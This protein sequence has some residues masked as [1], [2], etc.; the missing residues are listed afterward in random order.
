MGWGDDDPDESEGL[1]N[2]WNAEN[3]GLLHFKPTDYDCEWVEVWVLALNPREI[4]TEPDVVSP[5]RHS[6][7]PLDAQRTPLQGRS[8]TSLVLDHVNRSTRK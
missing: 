7:H 8:E 5:S 3:Q 4:V 1:G 2:A 6:E